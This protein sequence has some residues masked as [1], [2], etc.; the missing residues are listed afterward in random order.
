MEGEQAQ[1]Q[2]TN[3]PRQRN[4]A[5]ATVREG[6]DRFRIYAVAEPAPQQLADE[7]DL[8]G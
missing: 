4:E 1:E 6:L 2:G 3:C 5:Q 8:R 7:L